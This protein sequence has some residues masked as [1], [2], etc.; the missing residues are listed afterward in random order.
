MDD[1]EFKKRLKRLAKQ[2]K[3]RYEFD[4][5]RG[6]GSHGTVHYGDRKSTL[7]KGEIGEGLLGG[8]L[9]QLRINKEDF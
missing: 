3:V 6:K 9:K 1:K 5:K 2:N 4:Q 7:K 8:M